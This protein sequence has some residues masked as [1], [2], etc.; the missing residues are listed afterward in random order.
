MEP[1]LLPRDK[2]RLALVPL[3]MALLAITGCREA[4]MRDL[5]E[6]LQ[7]RIAAGGAE[8]VGIYYHDLENGDVL[9]VIE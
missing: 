4:R 7:T 1:N 6:R 3:S 9:L 2:R 8:T 5:N